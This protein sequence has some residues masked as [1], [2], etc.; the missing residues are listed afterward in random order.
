MLLL[1]SLKRKGSHGLLDAGYRFF[2]H[3]EL[4]E[5]CWTWV[6]ATTAGG[7]GEF[8][9][10]G[11]PVGAHVWLYELLKG[12]VPE[13]LELDHLCRVHSCVRPS[14]LEAVT[15]LE[16]MRRGNYSAARDRFAAQTH[17]KNGH[18]FSE[19]N[20]YRYGKNYRQCRTCQTANNRKH[21]EVLKQRR[22]QSRV[23]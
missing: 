11:T 10:E 18:L 6:G 19:S 20:T 4:T 9:A 3:V 22:Q 5:T 2:R 21:K 7:Y 17:C 15:H 1:V 12:T 13:G 14:H 8:N 23:A 16:N